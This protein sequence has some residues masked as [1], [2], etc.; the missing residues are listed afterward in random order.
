MVKRYTEEQKQDM[1]FN[2]SYY[3]GEITELQLARIGK[4]RKASREVNGKTVTI[5]KQGVR[6]K[7]VRIVETRKRG[8]TSS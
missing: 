4:D 2:K 8:V 1:A 7:R 6:W 3:E 5:L